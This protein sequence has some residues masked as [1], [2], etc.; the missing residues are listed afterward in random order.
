M[1]SSRLSPQNFFSDFNIFL[2]WGSSLTR[3]A[4]RST[5]PVLQNDCPLSKPRLSNWFPYQVPADTENTAF[6]NPSI[7]DLFCAAETCLQQRCGAYTASMPAKG[8]PIILHIEYGWGFTG[9]W[10]TWFE[11]GLFGCPSRRLAR[12]YWAISSPCRYKQK[13]SVAFSPQANYTDWA[14]DTCWR[15]LVPSFADSGVSRGQRG[16]SLAV[17]NP[18]FLDRSRYFS[19]K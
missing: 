16:G 7:A 17:V 3:G 15:I 10:C 14:T 11:T 9:R 4:V 1:N 19:F 6:K 8:L 13:N 2:K 12:V 18:S 5:R